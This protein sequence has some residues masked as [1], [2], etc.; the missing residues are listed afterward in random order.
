M[1][2]TGIS[3]I[4]VHGRKKEERPR[5]P[6]DNEAIKTISQAIR[7]PVIANGGS[8]EI[9]SHSDILKFKE[10]TGAASV[11]IARA[12]EANA[13]IFRKEGLL[14]LDEVIKEYIRYSVLFENHVKNIKY[15]I[16]HMMQSLQAS[17][18][19]Q[20]LLLSQ[21]VDEIVDIWGMTDFYQEIKFQRKNVPSYLTGYDLIEERSVKR[22]KVNDKENDEDSDVIECCVQFKR[23]Y[24]PDS[25]LPKNVLHNFSKTNLDVKPVYKTIA[26]DKKFYCEL[27]LGKQIFRTTFLEK[28]KMFA[29]QSAALIAGVFHNIF[30]SDR[31]PDCFLEDPSVILKRKG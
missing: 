8:G 20:K 1:E 19:G 29:E 14:P 17:E 11:M 27:K 21:E 23:P 4:A 28:S 9:E 30:N 5:H 26:V 16:Q 31:V 12:F 3:G 18:R 2:S 22:L 25:K 15:V 13:S 7:I 6:N 10:E 24:F